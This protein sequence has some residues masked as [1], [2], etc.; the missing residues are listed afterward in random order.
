MSVGHPNEDSLIVGGYV[1]L[2]SE[3]KSRLKMR[4][5]ESTAVSDD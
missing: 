5:W 1:G 2:D 4:I 3:E